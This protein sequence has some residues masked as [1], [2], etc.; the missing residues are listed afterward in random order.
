MTTFP[1]SP[2]LMRG[3]I[4]A[5][6]PLK[7]LASVIVF[8]YNPT[9]LSRSL[10]ARTS[11]GGG[12]KAEALRLEGAPE[13]SIRLEV[14]LDATDQLEQGTLVSTTMGV[15]PQLASLEMLLYPPSATVIANAALALA[16]TIEIVPPEAPMTLFVWGAKRVLPVRLTAFSIT[17]EAYD[18]NLNPIRAKVSLDLQVLSYSDLLSTHPG[19][20]LFLAHQ[21]TKEAMAMLGSVNGTGGAFTGNFG[22]L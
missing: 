3:A 16:G 10:K 7:P 22:A 21:V 17:E 11:G 15:H 20:H 8:Q 13:E 12:S 14:K 1:G 9:T 19:Y 5:I 2:R 4:L 6:D 18:T